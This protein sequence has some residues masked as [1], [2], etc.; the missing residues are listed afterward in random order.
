ML[1][2]GNKELREVRVAPVFVSTLAFNL[3]MNS[4]CKGRLARYIGTGT[5]AGRV[6]CGMYES[7][8]IAE[9]ILLHSTNAPHK[10]VLINTRDVIMQEHTQVYNTV[11]RQSVSPAYFRSHFST[12]CCYP[13]RIPAASRHEII[14]FFGPRRHE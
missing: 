6:T 1:T 14:Y 13:V 12:P 9:Q 11:Y 10:A 5:F 2:L 7:I 4:A 8:S 3:I